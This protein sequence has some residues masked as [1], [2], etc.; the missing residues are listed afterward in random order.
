MLMGVVGGVKIKPKKLIQLQKAF[1][2]S[3]T[4][5]FCKT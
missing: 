5:E 4:D 1:V 3:K 2:V